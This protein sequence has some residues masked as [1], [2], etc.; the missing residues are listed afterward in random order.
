MS[1]SHG[2]YATHA[3]IRT[4]LRSSPP[5]GGPSPLQG[6]LP[7]RTWRR[8]AP[9]STHSFGG[10][11]SPVALSAPSHSTSEL[12]RTLSRMAASKPTSWLSERLD[13]LS[14]CSLHLGT[15]A[16]GL[17]CFPLD[18]ES[19]HPPS[20]FARPL[21]AFMV[22][23]GSVSAWPPH[24]ASSLP[25]TAVPAPS[26]RTAPCARAEPQ[27]I[28]GRTSYLRVRL[29]F[30]PYPPLIPQFCNTGECAPPVRVTGPSHWP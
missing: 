4:S 26:L 12:L 20:H 30:H 24:P 23:L 21:W 19:S 11:L 28:S 16:D 18:D 7:Y 9:P 25:P 10:G 2:Q 3:G 8:V 15:L 17:G 27:S 14:H 6:T 5:S 29:A 13:H 1:G 22:W